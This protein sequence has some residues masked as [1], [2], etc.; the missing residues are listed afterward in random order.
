MGWYYAKGAAR[1]LFFREFA[2]L[3]GGQ[4]TG[5]DRSEVFACGH[6]WRR[7]VVEHLALVAAGRNQSPEAIDWYAQIRKA[8]RSLE[9]ARHRSKVRRSK[10]RDDANRHFPVLLGLHRLRRAPLI[11][12]GDRSRRRIA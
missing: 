2:P 5:E 6:L 1:A 7:L 10:T 12:S 4:R 8:L 3:V 11:T 9:A